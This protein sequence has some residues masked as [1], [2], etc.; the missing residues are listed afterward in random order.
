MPVNVPDGYGSLAYLWSL[1][2]DSEV[3]ATTIGVKWDAF[4][5]SPQACASLKAQQF[6]DATPVG[7]FSSAWTFKGC[8][9]R[10]GGAGVPG[11]VFVAPKA[12][13]GTAVVQTLPQNCSFLLRKLSNLAGRRGRGRMYWPCFLGE[14]SQVDNAGNIP[15]PT[16]TNIDSYFDQALPG[17]DFYILHNTL[18]SVLAPTL[19]TDFVLDGKIATQRR[20]LR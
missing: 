5:P 3:M 10:T 12:H 13:T 8:E 4:N 9:L 11:G 19:I 14:E 7:T 20:R 17:D 2:G 6:V 18:P 1:T 15:E 16:R